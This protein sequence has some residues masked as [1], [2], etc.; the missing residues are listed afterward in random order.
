MNQ[1]IY[2]FNYRNCFYFYSPEIYSTVI[3]WL[4]GVK[5]NL[6]NFL[7]FGPMLAN[8]PVPYNINMSRGGGGTACMYIH[9][10]SLPL[11]YKGK[12]FCIIICY[13]KIYQSIF[14]QQHIFHMASESFSCF[15]QKVGNLQNPFS[16]ITFYKSF[17]ERFRYSKFVFFQWHNNVTLLLNSSTKTI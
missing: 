15:A 16:K 7:L 9:A 12:Y 14:S 13:P 10:V 6:G 8:N 11:F 5:N 17:I 2:L 1:K 3:L 4:A